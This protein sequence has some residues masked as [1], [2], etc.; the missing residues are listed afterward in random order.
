LKE[1]TQRK[2]ST[3]KQTSP[4]E[5]LLIVRKDPDS[6]PHNTNDTLKQKKIIYKHGKKNL[7]I[8]PFLPPPWGMSMGG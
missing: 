3:Q 1:P 8:R 7:A 5:E 6:Y 4:V 2:K